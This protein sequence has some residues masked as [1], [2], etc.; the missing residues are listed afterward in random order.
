MNPSLPQ[1]KLRPVTENLGTE[2][3]RVRCRRDPEL[4]ETRGSIGRDR[5]SDTKCPGVIGES[6]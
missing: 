4:G 2:L 1:P 5:G 3:V 6:T